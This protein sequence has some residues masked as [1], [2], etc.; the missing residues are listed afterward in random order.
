MPPSFRHVKIVVSY[1]YCIISSQITGKQNYL[2]DFYFER[3]EKV[4]AI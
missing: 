1:K 4:D 2:K 3:L